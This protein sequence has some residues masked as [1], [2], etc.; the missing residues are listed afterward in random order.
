MGIE[1]KP[2]KY[3]YEKLLVLQRKI[4]EG[5]ILPFSGADPKFNPMASHGVSMCPGCWQ[6]AFFPFSPSQSFYFWV[7]QQQPLWAGGACLAWSLQPVWSCSG[8][9]GWV[10]LRVIKA[11]W[12]VIGAMEATPNCTR[13]SLD[14]ESIVASFLTYFSQISLWKERMLLRH[15]P[16]PETDVCRGVCV[17]LYTCLSRHSAVPAFADLEADTKLW[18]P[19]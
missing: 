9:P 16:C 7:R 19:P 12:G 17:F 11:I 13:H 5:N 4:L 18:P 10:F 14:L 2:E 6:A 8:A 1:L 15:L 3:K